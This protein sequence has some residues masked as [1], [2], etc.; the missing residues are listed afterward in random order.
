LPGPTG[1]RNLWRLVPRQAVVCLADTTTDRLVQLAAVLAT[2]GHA[3]WP[4]AGRALHATL[5]ATVAAHITLVSDWTAAGV[6]CDVVLL[7]GPAT[8]LIT[9][10]Q[11]LAQRP[12]PI[13]AIERLEPGATAIRLE[14]LVSERTIS[15]N[16]AAAGGN[17]ALMTLN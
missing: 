7:H 4:Q 11:A 16:T 2:G 8:T 12:G 5:P 3:V 1:E 15:I 10:Q 13:I 17:A 9:L 14:R 6:P